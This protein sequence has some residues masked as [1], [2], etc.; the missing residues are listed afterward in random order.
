[1]PDPTE[2]CTVQAG[3]SEYKYWKEVEVV[4]DMRQWTSQANLVVAELTTP[5]MGWASVRLPPG[6][7]AKVMM[8]GTLVISGQVE[9]RQ[10]AYDGENHTVRLMILSKNA[11]LVKSTLDLPPG[12]FKNQTLKQLASAAAGK[13]GIAFNLKGA[14]AGAEKVFERVSVHM[15]ESPFQFIMRLA[16]MRNVHTFDDENGNIVGQRGATDVVATLQEGRNIL[17]AEL[18]WSINQMVGKI[19]ADGD[20]HANDEHWGD[21]ARAVA[22][23]A[24]RKDGPASVMQNIMRII[25]PQ[26]GD[27]KDAQMF[28]NHAADLNAAKDF[29]AN[30]TVR[31]WMN[32]GKP[33]I[34][35]V[36]KLVM[37]N[38]PMLLPQNTAKLGIQAVTHRQN[39]QTGTTTTLNLCLPARLGS[40]DPIDDSGSGSNGSQGG[41]GYSPSTPDDAIPWAPDDI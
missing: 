9:V 37:L 25:A 28:A 3:G 6:V 30:V 19:I 15:G 38:S 5:G 33:W 24:T 31:G 39:D 1:M 29:E 14:V 27:V 32:G 20:N 4:R 22:A 11:D 8:A 18:V 16:Q 12:Q 7:E 41:G 34:L 26:Q 10:A 2:I 36:G 21:K 40:S 13:F 17:A 35:D 23:Q